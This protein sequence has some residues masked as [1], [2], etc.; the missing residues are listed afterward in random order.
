MEH[1]LSRARQARDATYAAATQITSTL[2]LLEGA[3]STLG[4]AGQQVAGAPEQLL[5]RLKEWKEGQPAAGPAATEV[6][7][8]AQVEADGDTREV[9]VLGQASKLT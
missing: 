3:R 5:Q 7:V 4:T 8:E 2:D 1:S 9:G 6:A